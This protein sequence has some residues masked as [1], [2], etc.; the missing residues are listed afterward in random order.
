MAL[1]PRNKATLLTAGAV[2]LATSLVSF[3][4]IPLLPDI[5]V[6]FS[7]SPAELS[8]IT[9]SF[10]LGRLAA[11]LPAGRAVDRFPAHLVLTAVGAFLCAG[12]ILFGTAPSLAQASAAVF[13]IGVASAVANTAGMVEFSAHSA[14]STRGRSMAAFTI[15]LLSGQAVGP[16]FGGLLGQ[17]AGWRTAQAGCVVVGACVLAGCL[18]RRTDGRD[19]TS[20][21]RKKVGPRLVGVT[22]L[23]WA[24]RL[25]L[26]SSR[27]AVF[28][29][30][31]ALVQTFVPLI[32]GA[33]LGL[34]ASAIGVALAV[35]GVSRF[36]GA[37]VVGSVSDRVSRKAALVPSL[38]IMGAGAAML[39]MPP[40]VA[41]WGTAIA[42]LAAGSAGIS[43]AAAMVGDRV[44]PEQLGAEMSGFRFLGDIGMLVGPILVGWLYGQAGRG[45]A[46]LVV[47]VAL[48][49]C[50][51]VVLLLLRDS[52]SVGVENGAANA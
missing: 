29:A 19:R 34:S 13:L 48:I 45:P 43:A 22:R 47:S 52:Y 5:A 39:A 11:D 50:A 14:A 51:L 38:V 27:F 46:M 31:S 20:S 41:L 6:E 44:A 2:L 7:L 18:V 32:G 37:S 4:R 16:L 10:A 42:L 25:I 15:V 9:A 49:G 33:V 17:V 28:F 1:L 12:S 21:L 8:M 23:R 40:S 30:M 26:G 3:S 36:A 35:G 24:E